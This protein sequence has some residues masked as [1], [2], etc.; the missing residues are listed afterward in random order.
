MR[1]IETISWIKAKIQ[2]ELFPHLEEN[3]ESDHREARK[4][5]VHI[6]LGAARDFWR[7]FAPSRKRDFEILSFHATILT[8]IN[9]ISQRTT[10]IQGD[11]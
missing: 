9:K 6:V 8:G 7:R 3:Y 11:G 4:A 10:S 2:S 5:S 1:L